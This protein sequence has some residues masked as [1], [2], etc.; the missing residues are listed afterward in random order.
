MLAHL[1]Q[2][3]VQPESNGVNRR[4]RIAQLAARLDEL[5]WAAEEE[6]AALAGLDG[7][8]GEE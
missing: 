4:G 8:E 2:I 7:E 5:G 3:P 1:P 6:M